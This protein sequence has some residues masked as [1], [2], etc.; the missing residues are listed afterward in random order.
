MKSV[1]VHF[2]EIKNRK[3]SEEMHM[4][5]RDFINAVTNPVENLM[6]LRAL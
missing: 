3:D 4:R 2:S 1:T 5:F 6:V